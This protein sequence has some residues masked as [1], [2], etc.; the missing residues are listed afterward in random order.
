M[1]KLCS[2]ILSLLPFFLPGCLSVEAVKVLATAPPYIDAGVTVSGSLYK[3]MKPV[4]DSEEY[5]IGKAVAAR[6]LSGYKLLDNPKLTAY[7][8]LVG[9]TVS[10]SSDRP[11]L[12]GGYHF[13]VLDSAEINAFA[14]PGGIVFITKGMLDVAENEDELAAVFAHEIAHINNYDG[15]ASIK[16]SRWTAALAAA[17][18]SAAKQSGSAGV[19][20]LAG[21]FQGVVDD[22]FKTIVVNGYGKTCEYA[23]D[24]ACLSFLARA[25]YD[26]SKMKDFLNVLSRKGRSSEGGLFK[27]HP[28]TAERID[29]V[30]NNLPS[31]KVD[32][33]LVSLRAERFFASLR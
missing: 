31:G 14:C 33:A 4:S 23:A 16:R 15:I 28:A 25:G 9:N 13:A 6:I 29:N 3:A 1:K 11:Y 27:T 10:L 21:I 30:R 20:E 17:G 18:S 7:V 32:S 12:Y 5:Y 26:P 22:V 19:S 8:N 24:E 2:A